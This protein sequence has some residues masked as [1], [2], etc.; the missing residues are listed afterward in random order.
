MEGGWTADFSTRTTNANVRLEQR[1]DGFFNENGA[2]KSFSG[3][4][5]E[6]N[7]VAERA[8]QNIGFSMLTPFDKGRIA[9]TKQ[10]FF[11]K[12][13]LD[14][15]RVY[16]RGQP[17][18]MTQFFSNGMKKFWSELN[19]NDG[20][21]GKLM[22][23][24]PD[25]TL[26]SQMNRDSEGRFHGEAREYSEDGKLKAHLMWEHGK[27][28]RILFE[29]PAQTEHRLEKYGKVSWEITPQ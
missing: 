26:L 6:L 7:F 27:I 16:R 12:G 21:E 8:N 29:T 23:W 4:N 18:F 20:G 5:A 15:E 3:V 2:S 14:Q 19:A 22:V 24:Y 17:Q 11:P 25:G 10:C 28:V 13:A 9:G 1:A